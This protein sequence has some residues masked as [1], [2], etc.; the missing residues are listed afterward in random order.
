MGVY[1]TKINPLAITETHCGYDY[2]PNQDW[3]YPVMD[4]QHPQ[5]VAKCCVASVPENNSHP[6]LWKQLSWNWVG[7]T[8]E[9]SWEHRRRISCREWGWERRMELHGQLWNCQ[10][11]KQR[12]K[13]NAKHERSTA[14]DGERKPK[15]EPPRGSDR[16][17]WQSLL[18][19]GTAQG[20]RELE[21]GWEVRG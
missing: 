8:W 20:A 9:K 6:H 18:S 1:T 2:L 21:T 10:G 3:I 5:P 15:R 17:T 13:G 14:V 4:V 19:K 12:T 7:P 11:I 16:T